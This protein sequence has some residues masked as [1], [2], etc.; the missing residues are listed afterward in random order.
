MCLTF[1]NIFTFLII[2][3]QHLFKIAPQYHL[4]KTDMEVLNAKR[5]IN[6]FWDQKLKPR[7]IVFFRQYRNVKRNGIF[8]EGIQNKKAADS[9][10]ISRSHQIL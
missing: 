2:I 4:L 7:T 10:Q 6:N 5:K 3:P 8:N 9:A 1:S